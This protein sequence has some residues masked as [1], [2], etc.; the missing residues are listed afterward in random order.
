MQHPKTPRGG[1]DPTPIED[2]P[3]PQVPEEDP[4]PNPPAP[5]PPEPIAG[6]GTVPG[7]A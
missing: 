4:P 1:G 3:E 6:T 5:R 7:R 2:P